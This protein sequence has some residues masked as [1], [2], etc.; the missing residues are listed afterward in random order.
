MLPLSTKVKQSDTL[1]KTLKQLTPG[2]G[3]GASGAGG[4][5]SALVDGNWGENR[6][7]M[8]NI[9]AMVMVILVDVAIVVDLRGMS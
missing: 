7:R 9:V 6:E 4:E 5:S 3:A 2:L 8:R 1:T